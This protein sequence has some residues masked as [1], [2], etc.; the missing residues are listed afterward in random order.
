MT[1]TDP[2]AAFHVRTV[3]PSDWDRVQAVLVD[4][5]GGR[6][7]TGLLPRLFFHHFRTTSFV[8]DHD[9][10]LAAF[11]VGFLCPTHPE[12]AYVHFVGVDPDLR[13]RGIATALYGRFFA[14]ARADGRAVVR[15][16]TSPVNT[17]SVAFH[18]RLGFHAIPGDAEVDGVPVWSNH[19][20]PAEPR[21][22]FELD[23]AQTPNGS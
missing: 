4:W 17:G 6:D 14:L 19:D 7:L 1:T 23:L 13:G 3:D 21:V 8:V 5:W 15:A 10:T 12:E 18:R 9:A 11:L 2:L 20:G 22:R 16:I